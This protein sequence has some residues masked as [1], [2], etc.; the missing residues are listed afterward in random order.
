MLVL[1]LDASPPLKTIP[2]LLVHDASCLATD[3]TLTLALALISDCFILGGKLPKLSCIS[4][5]TDMQVP[6]LPTPV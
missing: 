3:Q 2:S 4:V 1:H 6:H 5:L